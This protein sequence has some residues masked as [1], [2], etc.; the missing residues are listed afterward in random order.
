M[1]VEPDVSSFFAAPQ[2]GGREVAASVSTAAC[3][4]VR[5]RIGISRQREKSGAPVSKIAA[6]RSL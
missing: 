4:S 6:K 2:C 1:P 3:A 5:V